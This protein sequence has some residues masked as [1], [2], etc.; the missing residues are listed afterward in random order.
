MKR[1]STLATRRAPVLLLAALSLGGPA[2]LHAASPAKSTSAPSKNDAYPAASSAKTAAAPSDFV[3]CP[4]IGWPELLP[5]F[6][7]ADAEFPTNDT[8]GTNVPDCAFH[9]WS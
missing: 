6:L 7:Q 3:N 5:H 2:V 1:P 9:Q 8:A 4:M